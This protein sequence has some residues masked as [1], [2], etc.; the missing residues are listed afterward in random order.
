MDRTHRPCFLVVDREY[1]GSISTRKLVIET[2]KFNVLTAYSV[3]EA[4][5][6]LRRFPAVDGIVVDAE[7]PEMP[8]PDLVRSLKHLAPSVPVIIVH[9]PLSEPC[10]GAE[11][12]LDTFDP[13]QLLGLLQSL[14]PEQAK[15][16]EER[17]ESLKAQ[18]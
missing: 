4:L 16:V 12:Q 7:M 2:A 15:A 1:S 6:T 3:A 9:R 10:N 11:Y 18:E 8:C 14:C 5:T 13:K 17:N